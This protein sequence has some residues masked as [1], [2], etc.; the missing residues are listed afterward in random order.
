MEKLISIKKRSQVGMQLPRIHSHLYFFP[1]WRES[2]NLPPIKGEDT[3]ESGE[4]ATVPRVTDAVQIPEE[5]E[6]KPETDTVKDYDSLEAITNEYELKSSQQLKVKIHYLGLKT[7]IYLKEK[8]EKMQK[9]DE[10]E[11]QKMQVLVSS[12]FLKSVSF[13]PHSSQ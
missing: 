13:T 9:V 8:K 5:T 11:I 2:A 1:W 12:F 3:G 6:M 7:E 10:D 4:A